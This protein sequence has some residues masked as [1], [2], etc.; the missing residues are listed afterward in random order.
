MR[1][2]DIKTCPTPAT[3]IFLDLRHLDK[4]GRQAWHDLVGLA[5]R[6]LGLAPLVSSFTSTPPDDG[7][8][9]AVIASSATLSRKLLLNVPRLF[10]QPFAAPRQVDAF[11][12]C[13]AL[14]QEELPGTIRAERKVTLISSV[15][16]GDEFLEGFI[17]NMAALR[18]YSECEHLLIR[19]GSPG[20]EHGRLVD[21]VRQHPE[22]VYI[23]LAKDPGLYEVWNFGIRLATGRYLSNANIDDRRAPQQVA[24][25][26]RILDTT[27]EVSV[28][29]TPLRVST[30]KNLSW[31]DSTDRPLMFADKDE[32]I[33]NVSCLL[34]KNHDGLASR[35][36]PHCM[37]IWRRHLHTFSGE[38][39]EKRYGP[40]ADWAFWLRAGRDGASFFFVREPLGLYLRDDGSYWRRNTERADFDARILAEFGD[41]AAAEAQSERRTEHGGQPLGIAL[42]EAIDNLRHG[43]M[44]D[45]IGRLLSAMNAPQVMTATT[46]T[47]VDKTCRHF[48][49][50]FDGLDWIARFRHG[51][52]IKPLPMPVLFNALADLI[53]G[54][55]L[56]ALGDDAATVHRNLSI[57][58]IDW[59]ECFADGRGLILLAFLARQNGQHALEHF[60]LKSQYGENRLQFWRTVQSA[61]RFARPLSEL[62]SGLTEISPQNTLTTKKNDYHIS[63]YPD[64]SQGNQ[65]QILVY[66]D[67]IDEGAIVT[68]TSDMVKFVNTNFIDGMENVLH[69]HWLNQIF[70]QTIFSRKKIISQSQKFIK[71]I[72]DAKNRG[73]SIYWTIHNN[74]SHD[75]PYVSDELK[76]SRQLYTLSD[77]VFVHHPL[78]PDLLDWLP[79][80]K[81]LCLCEHGHYDFAQ[82]MDTTYEDARASLGFTEHD[83]IVTHVGK[84]RDYKKLVTF[85]PILTEQLDT[86]PSM[87]LVIAGKITSTETITWLSRNPHPR[88]IVHDAFLSE[89]ELV[90]HM[91]A[92]DLGFLSYSTILTSG[93][94][95]HWQTCGRPVLAPAMGTIPAYLIDGWNGVSYQNRN[96]LK[97][98]LAYCVAQPK[99]ELRRMGRNALAVAKQLDWRLW[100]F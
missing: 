92:A 55:D 25:L 1:F 41:L 19:P 97:K 28:A 2:S 64:Y 22:A 42:A 77:K 73:F 82:A 4:E 96:S 86:T 45:G 17:S 24:K 100:K 85:L 61:Y 72:I 46:Q 44:L 75:S 93:G 18:D 26:R 36:L 6:S 78:V 90:L 21:H 13:E 29:S 58:C 98:R 48:F 51:A 57:A 70:G 20:D 66:K 63:Y 27:P 9:F 84:I 76:F 60:L 16:R 33:Y 71:G 80:Q 94:L 11:F 30:Q 14:A 43:A 34:K 69:I 79:D 68:G 35:N 40:S 39:N 54:F 99:E 74:T 3:E 49:G 88:I 15:F 32:G 37:P 10:V 50:C 67:L 56:I 62:C 38:F 59:H 52:S 65:Y 7:S 31:E 81:K 5:I 83:L 8:N 47:L 53:H 91:R 89:K 95:F 23:N 87:K 12:H